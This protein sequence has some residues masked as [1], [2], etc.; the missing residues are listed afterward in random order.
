[1]QGFEPVGVGARGLAE[2]LALQLDDKGRLDPAISALLTRLDLVA[3]QDFPAL[4]RLCNVDN[5]E[6]V[7]MLAEIRRLNP[8]PGLSFSSPQVNVLSPDVIVR[9]THHAGFRV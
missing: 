8:K 1:V 6:L 4:R 9:A 5:N 2:C 3:K 7:E